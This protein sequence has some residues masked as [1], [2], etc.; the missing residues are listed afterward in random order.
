MNGTTV[1]TAD[2]YMPM[3]KEAGAISC[4]ATVDHKRIGILYLVTTF[5]FF[6]VGGVEALVMRLQ[7][8]VPRNHLV[9]P[10]VFNQ[11]FTMHGT[12]MIFLVVMPALIGFA[13][14][15]VPLMIGARDMAFPRLNAM[16][17]WLL[18]FGGLLLHFSVLAGG[19]PAAGWFSYT[20]LSESAYSSTQGPDYWILALLVMGVG[21]VAG[22]INM[23]VT[24]LT[25]R[26]PGMTMRL[27]PLFVWMVFINSI[28][29]VLAMPALNASIV[30]LLIDRQLEAH[31]FTALQGGAPI[32]WQHFFWTFGHPE[33]YIMVLPAF[34]MISEVVPVFSRKPIFGYGFVAGSTVAIALLSFGVWAH[35][36]FAVGLGRASDLFFAASS[37]AI[38]VPTGIKIFNWVFT[39]WGG[40]I[41][42]TTSLMFAVAFILQFVVGGLSG[43]TFAVAP[44]DWQMTDT[45]YVVAHFHY[46]LFGGTLFA[47]MAGLYYWFP[48]MS[49]RILS[50]KIGKAQFWLMVIGFNGTFMVQHFLGIMGMPRRAFTYPD[51]PGWGALNMISTVGAFILGFSVLLLGCNIVWSLRRG[52]QAGDNPWNAWTLEWATSS[53]PPEENFERVPEIHG[54]RPLWDLAHPETARAPVKTDF[55]PEKNKT[56]MI[57]FIVSEGFFFL[58]LIF[59]Y[60]YYNYTQKPGPD[61]A[62]S[63]DARKTLLFTCSLLASSFTIWRSETAFKRRRHKP[64]VLWL[65]ATI[66]LGA[67]FIIGQG[68]E[69]WG[70]LQRGIT[71]RT[72]L[73]ATTFFTLTGFHGL[74]VCIG[75][76]LLTIVLV[77]MLLGDFKNFRPRALQ[78]IGLYWHFV[79]A[80]WIVVFS[81]I[82]LKLLL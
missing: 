69:Y 25:L 24:I 50:E 75:L 23:I 36:M 63:L 59:A 33:V 31:F 34:G 10:G 55:C 66:V 51:L 60:I 71:I 70:L 35:H 17:Y 52:T 4:V 53:P 43:I 15:F 57:V 42:F 64:M 41:R 80:V 58:M 27:V 39:M 79:D 20:P 78:I 38:A 45:Y 54:R 67:I 49:G 3:A 9:G 16:S 14:Y 73:F 47:M 37:M 44:I 2:E 18:L 68:S 12:T 48:K 72:N 81:I 30:M 32:L 22:A 5:F 61:A 77:L 28:L 40:S 46:V 76:M 6:L 11:L 74:H 13:N 26:A 82:Y 7:L 62:S 1:S 65:I 56:S 29:I 21:T 8:A 19:A